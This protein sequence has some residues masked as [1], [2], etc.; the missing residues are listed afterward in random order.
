MQK[1]PLEGIRVIDFTMVVAGP[2][3]TQWLGVMGAEVIKIESS[4]RP[5]IERTMF[6]QPKG[7]TMSAAFTSY[8]YSKKDITLNMTQPKAVELVKELVKLSDIV[9]ENFGGPVL[10]RWGLGYPELK[11]LKPNIIVYSGSGY[12]RTGPLKES[13]AYAPIVDAFT[14]IS[15]MNGYF[16]GCFLRGWRS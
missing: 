13:P 16:G 2:H 5:D 15:F 6:K 10:E 4:L 14:G 8:N 9:T 12:G 11:K 1:L 3:L 7:P